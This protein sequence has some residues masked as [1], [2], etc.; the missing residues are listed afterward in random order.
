MPLLRNLAVARY[1]ELKS[2]NHSFSVKKMYFLP[3]D[4]LNFCNLEA[5]RSLII[6]EA[7]M[8]IWNTD[9][10]V[11]WSLAISMWDV[12]LNECVIQPVCVLH[13][14]LCI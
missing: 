8:M 5:M 6:A 14:H 13:L 11:S 4:L 3:G 2:L 12:R 1:Q 7:P 10:Q 9:K